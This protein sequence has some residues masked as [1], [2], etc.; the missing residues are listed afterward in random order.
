MKL[1]HI[2]LSVVNVCETADFFQTYFG[3]KRIVTKGE[4]TFVGLREE[5]GTT[6]AINNFKHDASVSYPDLFHI[7][8]FQDS[9]EQVDQIHERLKSGGFEPEQPREEHGSYTFYLRSPG[10]F[11]VEIAHDEQDY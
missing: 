11:L 9:R 3:F 1:N 2:N 6:M 8:F 4:D 5:T 7:G 10:G